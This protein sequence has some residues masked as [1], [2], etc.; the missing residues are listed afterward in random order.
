MGFSLCFMPNLKRKPVGQSDLSLGK[1]TSQMH[2]RFLTHFV[3][4]AGYM[5]KKNHRRKEIS[6]LE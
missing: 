1:F 6:K 3:S 2:T 5:R 4:E